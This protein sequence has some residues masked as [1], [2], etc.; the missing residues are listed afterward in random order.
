MSLCRQK[1]SEI[2][3]SQEFSEGPLLSHEAFYTCATEVEPGVVFISGSRVAAAATS[4]YLIEVDT[5]NVTSL[6]DMPVARQMHACGAVPSE[7]Y[8]GID[9]VAAGGDNDLTVDIFNTRLNVW[10]PGPALP[11][12]IE[13]VSIKE[14]NFAE[15]TLYNKHF[16]DRLATLH[17]RTPSSL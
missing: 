16:F 6:P 11:V 1:F 8:G 2:Y 13:L 14:R 17:M 10:R 4:A 5:G 3:E 15:K 9:I 7:A 12:E